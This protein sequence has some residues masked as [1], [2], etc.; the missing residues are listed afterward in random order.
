VT[1]RLRPLGSAAHLAIL[2]VGAS[3]A[4]AQPP[5]R[6]DVRVCAG[7]DVSLGTNLDTSWAI[8]RS[9][10][11][12]PA[13][14][15]PA[16]LVAPL[17]PL[18]TDARLVLLNVEGAIGEGR[19]PPKCSRRATQ[20]YAIR[21]PTG[22]AA[23]LRHLIDSGYVIGNVANNHAHDAGDAGFAHTLGELS[24]AGVLVTGADTLATPVAV[25][26]G[27]TV[28]VLGFS[29]WSIPDVKDIAAVRRHVSRAAA[30]YGRVL[31]TMHIGAE[32]AAARH[33]Y[34]RNE[35]FA[36]E[37]RGNSVAFAHAAIESGASLVIGH[38]PHVLRAMEW[39]DSAGTALVAYSLGNLVTYGPFNHEGY[40]DHG[41]ILCVTLAADGAIR[42]AS[43]RAT[44]QRRP[45][46]VAPD[47]GK[48]GIHDIAELSRTDFPRT[49]ISIL[50][51]GAIPQRPR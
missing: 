13:I 9:A 34:D 38:G 29:A 30:Q 17:R 18:L 50:P 7:G 45:G 19:V 21:Q 32:G 41:A 28:A 35:R 49:G 4:G 43:L 16:K 1:H 39:A 10:R 31:V 8:G 37:D 6:H 27:D 5:S 11:P 36:G 44:V 20:C 15:D 12:A 2:V 42:D 23:A 48:R 40:N 46:I 24:N 22:T 26:P 47:S 14:P 51:G 3:I 33:T 25:G